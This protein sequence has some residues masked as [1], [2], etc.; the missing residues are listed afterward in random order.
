MIAM[1]CVELGLSEHQLLNETSPDV[2]DEMLDYLVERAERE[3]R[4]QKLAEMRAQ[5]RKMS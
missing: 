5:I 1:M 3:K 4:S 2:F